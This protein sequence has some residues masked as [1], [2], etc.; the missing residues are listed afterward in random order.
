MDS[1][2]IE[3]QK[4][5]YKKSLLYWACETVNWIDSLTRAKQHLTKTFYQMRPFIRQKNYLEIIEEY[6]QV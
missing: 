4:K 1:K 6:W 5:K 3:N 2:I